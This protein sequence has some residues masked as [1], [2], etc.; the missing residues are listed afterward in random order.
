MNRDKQPAFVVKVNAAEHPLWKN[1][2]SLLGHL[3][4][5]LTERCNNNCI[6]CHINLPARHERARKREL[7]AAFLEAVLK[8]AATLGAL[9]VRLTGGEPL[10]REDF[11]D[12]YVCAR[13]LGLRVFL[14]TNARRMTPELADLLAQ[15]PPLEPIEVTVY[16]MSQASYEAVSRVAGSFAE[17]Q[18]GVRLLL[19]R[20]IPFVV[21]SVRLP[22]T[23][24]DREALESWA[25]TIPWMD[26]SP[27][28][29]MLLDLRTRRDDPDKNRQIAELRVRPKECVEVLRQGGEQYVDDSFRVC[30]R[31]MG[32]RGHRLFTCDAGRHVCLDAY[33]VL[34]PCMTLCHP[35]TVYDLK[36]GSLEDALRTFFPRLRCARA[37]N[38]KYAARCGRCFLRGFCDQCPAKSWTEHGT[39]DTPVQH[40]CDTAHARA[41]DLGLLGEKERGWEVEDWQ[42][43]IE[44]FGQQ[45]GET[46]QLVSPQSS[47]ALCE[48]M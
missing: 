8:D 25:A 20:S 48:T 18:R 31:F 14:S 19:D 36:T 12:I 1:R 44:L 40:L 47:V 26:R 16:G 10:L 33:G 9:S 46:G 30:T 13:R 21:R 5:E 4:I 28:E 37:S 15:I 24:D 43:R 7:S 35:E 17:F 6:H 29:V 11:A 41:R 3:D 32:P 42:E 23:E 45:R 27:P 2:A 38:P 22:Q 34:Q 39:L